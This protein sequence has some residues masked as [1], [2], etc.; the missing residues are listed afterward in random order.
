MQPSKTSGIGALP[1]VANSV[2]L[3]FERVKPISRSRLWLALR[4]FSE[5]IPVGALPAQ[6]RLFKSPAGMRK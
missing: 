4:S 1:F 5:A 2:N 6:P 3:R